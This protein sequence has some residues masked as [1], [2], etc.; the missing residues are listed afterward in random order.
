MRQAR[1]TSRRHGNARVVGIITALVVGASTV[2][3]IGYFA[4]QGASIKRAPTPAPTIEDLPPSDLTSNTTPGGPGVQIG[5]VT[6]FSRE[7]ADKNDP[8]RRAMLITAK[9]AT[10]LES[11]QYE[12]VEPEVQSFQDDGRLARFRAD[13][14][15]AYVPSDDRAARPER[16]TLTGGVRVEVFPPRPGR[17][18]LD[19]TLDHPIFT[20]TTD[21]LDY[22]GVLGQISTPDRIEVTS[23][24]LWFAGT[25][26]TMMVSESSQ[27]IESMRVESSEGIRYTPKARAKDE[28]QSP[29]SVASGTNSSR[30]PTPAASPTE[31][32]ARA[33]TMYHAMFHESVRVTQASRAITADELEVWFRSQG[34]QLPSGALGPLT[35]ATSVPMPIPVALATTAIAAFDEPPT[36]PDRTSIFDTSG[37]SDPIELHWTGPMELL[38][39]STTP[40]QLA[41]DDLALRFSAKPESVVAFNDSTSG[42]AATGDTIDYAATRQI[43]DLA[44]HTARQATMTVP[45]VGNAAGER[46]SVDLRRGIVSSQGLGR[47]A[48]EVKGPNE[49]E[50]QSRSVAWTKAAEFTF[51]TRNERMT[52]RLLSADA[53]GEVLAT[54]PA[55]TLEG[56]RIRAEFTPIESTT[57]ESRLSLLEVSEGGVAKA[58]SGGSLVAN[59]IVAEFV[60]GKTPRDATVK[61]ITATGAVQGQRDD[62]RIEADLLAAELSMPDDSTTPIITHARAKGN[63]K[64]T[65]PEGVAAES[66][67]LTALPADET[68]DF[69]GPRSVISHNGTTI[70]GAQMRLEGARQRLTVFGPGEITHEPVVETP[71]K[72]ERIATSWTDSMEFDDLSGEAYC[73]GGVVASWTVDAINDSG[74]VLQRAIDTLRAER[75]ELALT[76]GL[77]RNAPMDTPRIRRRLL[78]ATATGDTGARSDDSPH[79]ARFE[80]RRLVPAID[81]ATPIADEPMALTQLL[82]VES[83]RLLVDNTT[84]GQAVLSAPGSGRLLLVDRRAPIAAIDLTGEGTPDTMA[85]GDAL[86]TWNGSLRMNQADYTVTMNDSVR[87]THQRVG[88]PGGNVTTVLDCHLLRA[89]L[90][91]EEVTPGQSPD[92]PRRSRGELSTAHA[93][94]GVR[95]RSGRRTV[96]GDLLDYNAPSGEVIAAA[97]AGRTV[98]VA[99]EN[100]AGSMTA[101]KILWNLR[102]GRIDI[103]EGTVTAPR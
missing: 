11:R 8:T 72:R 91:V 74:V 9:S 28:P 41:N 90:L 37:T 55:G 47:L 61:S 82:F 54:D 20:A 46:F 6:G 66:D 1:R 68:V 93:E 99:D 97:R 39:L 88:D 70:T 31:T 32:T 92:G 10:P 77:P 53:K 58:T 23:E 50:P 103:L 87:L 94:G 43:L 5:K 64:Y 83:D 13:K 80:S 25:G 4:I 67:E 71:G 21:S 79:T 18:T 62:S 73:S 35:R 78:N 60:E 52:G 69:I 16:V 98:S 96:E 44:G 56:E 15:Q 7:I 40:G 75:V 101:P 84:D 48:A 26:V 59:S 12:L 34:T 102:S 27:T 95:M 2:L 42:S 63:V 81:G 17:T 14:G 65:G 38:P 36:S 33:Q 76:P 100:S 24:E 19:P 45:S 30:P 85:R 51:E 29:T 49:T 3:L 57:D 89:K 86:F 22:D